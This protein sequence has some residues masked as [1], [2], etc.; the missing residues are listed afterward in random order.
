MFKI[1]T[2]L[3]LEKIYSRYYKT[4][5]NQFSKAFCSKLLVLKSHHEAQKIGHDSS[6]GSCSCTTSKN[7]ISLSCIK[8]TRVVF[9]KLMTSVNDILKRKTNLTSSYYPIEHLSVQTLAVTRLKAFQLIK[10]L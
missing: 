10:I 6:M 9:F 2:G 7:S 8:A 4:K 1:F 3:H 5:E